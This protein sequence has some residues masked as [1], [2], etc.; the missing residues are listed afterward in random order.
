[1]GSREKREPPHNMHGCQQ[2][3]DAYVTA[4][5]AREPE[6]LLAMHCTS[7]VLVSDPD[8]Q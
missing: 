6:H 7:G 5:P 2:T 4:A 3:G 8:R 1:M